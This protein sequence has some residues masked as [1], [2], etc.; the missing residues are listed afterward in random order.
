MKS[1]KR[2]LMI[3]VLSLV[4]VATTNAQ[5]R[6]I[7][8]RISPVVH[9]PGLLMQVENVAA[10]RPVKDE[11]LA[12]TEKF[13]QGASSVAEI[14]LDP[15]TMSMLGSTRHGRDADLAS[16]LNLMSVRSYTYD[17][18]GMYSADDVEAFRKKLDDGSWSCPIRVRGQNGTSEICSRSSADHVTNELVIFSAYPQKV[19]FIHVSGKM[20]LEELSEASRSAGGLAPHISPEP[21][22]HIRVPDDRRGPGPDSTIKPTPNQ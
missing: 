21:N 16:K 17:K 10:S 12:G 14:D 20:T 6:E 8:I 7:R 3:L 22:I 19:N 11:L 18:P 13:A 1:M 9:M 15:T 4:A 2:V 5:E